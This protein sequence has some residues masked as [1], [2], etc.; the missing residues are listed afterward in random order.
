MDQN[1]TTT[2]GEQF[3]YAEHCQMAALIY[4]RF[5]NNQRAATAAWCRMMEN[6]TT[7]SDFMRLVIDYKRSQQPDRPR[8]NADRTLTMTDIELAS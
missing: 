5:G 6:S 7:A 8:G 3:T 1:I 2:A 4:K